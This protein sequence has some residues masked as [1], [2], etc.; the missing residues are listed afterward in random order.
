MI[1]RQEMSKEDGRYIFLARSKMSLWD[2]HIFI[3][4][5]TKKVCPCSETV[6][7]SCWCSTAEN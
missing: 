4:D 6:G 7:A 2:S 1:S 5:T 3:K